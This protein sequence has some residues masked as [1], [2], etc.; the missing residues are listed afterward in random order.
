MY[1]CL[2]RLY[3]CICVSLKS[4]TCTATIVTSKSNWTPVKYT[5]MRVTHNA[6]PSSTL[7]DPTHTFTHPPTHTHSHTLIRRTVVCSWE[8]HFGPIR[9]VPNPVESLKHDRGGGEVR[10]MTCERAR[11]I[12]IVVVRQEFDISVVK[13]NIMIP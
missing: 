5:C 7:C 12:M 11:S 6:Y 10:I 8:G 3:L 9:R 4:T 1:V 2:V 13:R